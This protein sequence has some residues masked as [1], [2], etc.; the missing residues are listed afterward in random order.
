LKAHQIEAAFQDYAEFTDSGGTK[1]PPATWLELCKGAEE[2][3]EF[4]RALAEYQQLAQTYPAERQ[5]LTAQL[6]AARLCLKRLNRPQDALTLYQTAAASPIP[7]LDW[8][9]H[10]Q[11]GIKEAKAAMSSG[12]A[13]G[14]GA[15]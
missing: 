10:I 11:S 5:S 6:S 12:N 14:A 8:E 7:H 4:D 9:Q 15:H 13:I 1:M 2:M 3:Q